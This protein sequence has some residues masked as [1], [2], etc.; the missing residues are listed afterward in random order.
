MKK[1]LAILLCLSIALGALAG[2][3]GQEAQTPSTEPSDYE[4]TPSPTEPPEPSPTEPPVVLTMASA[5]EVS[6]TNKGNALKKAL[7]ELKSQSGGSLSIELYE[8]GEKGTDAEIIDAVKS[9]GITIY[10]GSASM[11]KEVIPQLAVLEIPMMFSSTEG[12]NAVLAGAVTDMMQPFFNEAGMQLIG[13]YSTS[14]HHFTSSAPI[15]APADLK[16]LRMT[17]SKSEYHQLFWKTLGCNVLP[18][19]RSQVYI[20]LKQGMH[21]AQENTFREINTLK[22]FEV[23]SSLIKTRHTQD[24]G[25]YIMNK[26]RYDALTE[27]QRTLISQFVS[28]AISNETEAVAEDEAS[29]ESNF[30]KKKMAVAEPD[31]EL[32][33]AL[34]AAV[35]TV[36]DSVKKNIDPAFVDSYIAA[37]K[38]G[39]AT[40]APTPPETTDEPA[41]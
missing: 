31:S 19:E 6:G 8:G 2:C 34:K 27:E 3:A 39:A 28:Q 24:V 40:P 16:G 22:L 29:Q 36:V 17:T 21:G 32:L 41:E 37:C 4:E 15:A 10:M 11:M 9:G 35:Q 14:F 38:S 7:E 5:A 25:L 13:A 33:A 18:L 26:E 30:V 20:A 1:I 12:C 23:Q